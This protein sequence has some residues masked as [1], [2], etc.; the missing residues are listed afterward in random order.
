MGNFFSNLK[1]NMSRGKGIL[2]VLVAIIAGVFGW[3]YFHKTSE[4]VPP[5][6]V[7]SNAMSVDTIQGQKPVD[8]EYKDNLET[9]DETRIT[10]A[11]AKNDSAV[12]TV[13]AN[14]AQQK[15]VPINIEPVD[16][17]TPLVA[18]P[19][20][21]I[22]A[23]QPISVQQPVNDAL[24]VVSAPPTAVAVVSPERVQQMVQAMTR[25]PLPVA[26][27]VNWGAKLPEAA[28]PTQSDVQS[29]PAAAD[30]QKASKIK[31]PLPGTILY[32]ELIGRANSDA[33]GPVL[34][35]VLQG[36]YTG[37]TLIGSFQTA[38]NALVISFDRMTVTKT[39]SGEEINETVD[40]KG[41]AVDTK[42][43]GSALAT[44]VDRH[45]FQKL[46]IAFTTGFAQGFGDAISQNGSTTIDTSNGTITTGGNDL[47][48]KEQLYKAGGTAVQN[49]GSILQQ[50]YGNRPTTII[51]EQ[52]TPIG[53]LFL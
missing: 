22:L 35:R 45:L 29:S 12:P 27:V 32:A 30:A 51:V 14:T 13:V 48:A 6:K 25:K 8:P 15:D 4:V 26:E 47:N 5:S 36:E 52:G 19:S 21:D 23:Q 17:G 2:L 28:Q 1:G 9:A 18:T 41:T 20:A 10:E 38:Q 40:I 24:P 11:K 42:Y 46:A 16:T 43:I 44:E 39:L 50:E 37:A 49:A 53:V 3:S 34:A 7:A 31:I 33:P